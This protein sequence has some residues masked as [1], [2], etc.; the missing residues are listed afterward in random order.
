M[1]GPARELKIREMLESQ[2]FVDIATLCEVLDSSESTVRRDLV[3]L[4]DAGV[5]RRVHGGAM[6]VRSH[7][8]RGDDFA[9]HA[10]RMVAEKRR[11]AVATAT[12]LIEDGQ[13]VILDAGSTV[14]AVARELLDRSL[15]VVTNSLP[16]AEILGEARRIDVTLTGGQLDPQFGVVLGPLCEQM[17]GGLAVDV[18]VM[19]IGGVTEKG[20]SNSNPLVVGSERKMIEVARRVIIVSD[21]TKFGRAA[22][23]PLAPLDVVD[24][25]VSDTGLDPVHGEWLRSHDIEVRLV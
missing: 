25:V 22:L 11:I 21:H 6:A 12:Q 17:L 10:R 15:H 16:I 5:L 2:G 8:S 13:T 4:Q 7:G 24:V 19:G 3:A 20:L 1:K 14:A 23:V 9:G 18:A